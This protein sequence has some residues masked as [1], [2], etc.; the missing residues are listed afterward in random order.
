VLAE[1]V[2]E[3]FFGIQGID[4]S[5]SAAHRQTTDLHLLGRLETCLGLVLYPL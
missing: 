1:V 5:L 3:P 2:T 4:G